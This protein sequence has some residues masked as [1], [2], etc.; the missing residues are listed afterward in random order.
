MISPE[1]IAR[2]A[3]RQYRAVLRAWLTE[4]ELFPMNFSLGK[5]APDLS[6]RR[7]EIESLREAAKETLG[8]G[9]IL[10]WEIINQR[11]LGKQTIP[12]SAII[13]NLG[14]Y[15]AFLRK[16][17]EFDAFTSDVNLI[18]R[19]LPDLIDWVK[20]NPHRVVEYHGIWDD[21]LTVCRYFMENPRPNIYIRELP[22]PVQTKFVEAH[23]RILRDLLDTLLPPSAIKN[24]VSD[25]TTRYGL[26]DRTPLI[27]LRLLENQLEWRHGLR[28][29]D[30]SL[31][32]DQAADLLAD[33][34]RPRLVIVVENLIN[35][36]TLP[37]L[38]DVVGLFG[39]GFG[40]HLLHKL[41]WLNNC[42]LWYW[43]DIDAHGFSILSDLRGI[44]PH[45]RSVMMDQMTFDAYAVYAVAGIS[46]PD[47]RLDYLTPAETKLAEYVITHTLRLEQERLP[48]DYALRVLREHFY[49]L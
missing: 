44:F 45:T 35:F 7:R 17:R 14:D 41:S 15:I 20:D 6:I 39:A 28:I 30:L 16:R 46:A 11:T 27:R 26:R 43:G 9:Y 40:I 36:L 34:L 37:R 32:V 48:H 38:S 8:Y 19:R 4:S 33:H 25:F 1:D 23:T 18:R 12:R 24:D 21:L 3:E 31:P 22:I 10:D 47:A 2:K 42:E 13:A 49:G 29:D 5:P